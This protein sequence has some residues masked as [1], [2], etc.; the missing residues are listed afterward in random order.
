[1]NQTSK[2]LA[3]VNIQVQLPYYDGARGRA[4]RF[5]NDFTEAMSAHGYE[6]P[7]WGI[8]LRS[9]LK[10]QALDFFLTQKDK[11]DEWEGFFESFRLFFDDRSADN[12]SHYFSS[13]F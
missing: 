8:H 4:S 6:P 5:I 2:Q 1:M 13:I 12:D 3:K 9:C 10:K 7:Q 11:F